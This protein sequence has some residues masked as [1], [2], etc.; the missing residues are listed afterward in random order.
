MVWQ[1]APDT[2]VSRWTYERRAN[3]SDLTPGPTRLLFEGLGAL[4]TSQKVAYK[5]TRMLLLRCALSLTKE[6]SM[7]SKQVVRA[8]S[9]RSALKTVL[10]CTSTAKGARRQKTK[11]T[12]RL[13]LVSSL[14]APMRKAQ[15]RRHAGAWSSVDAFACCRLCPA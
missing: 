12:T 5:F 6:S 7:H 14:Q 1:I 4:C 15:Q 2:V 13:T 11:E 10:N 8:S 9:L 3:G